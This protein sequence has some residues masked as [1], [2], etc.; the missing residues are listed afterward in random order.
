M[1]PGKFGR[2]RLR[3]NALSVRVAWALTISMGSMLILVWMEVKR[4]WYP[5]SGLLGTQQVLEQFNPSRGDKDRQ[6]NYDR[7]LTTLQLMTFSFTNDLSFLS[8]AT[9]L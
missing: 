7:H 2:A 4:V 5:P 8:D 3:C 6:L 1:C 9:L